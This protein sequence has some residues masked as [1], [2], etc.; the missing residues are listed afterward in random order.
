MKKNLLFLS[1]FVLSAAIS[2]CSSDKKIT[3]A[4]KLGFP[5]GKKV[6]LF[7][8]DDGGMCDEANIAIRQIFN[9]LL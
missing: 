8:C 6:I 1:V 9:R 7:H 3:N 5:E 2:A 4:E